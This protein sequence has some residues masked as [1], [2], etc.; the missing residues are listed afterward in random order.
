MN[1]YDTCQL[2]QSKEIVDKDCSSH[3]HC[4]SIE[5]AADKSD[6]AEKFQVIKIFQGVYGNQKFHFAV[7]K[8]DKILHI[9]SNINKILLLEYI[10]CPE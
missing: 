8:Y 9:L 6:S 4:K 1:W 5:K 3:E 10:S 7:N 2:Y